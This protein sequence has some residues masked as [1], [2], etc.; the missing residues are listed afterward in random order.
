ML[1]TLAAPVLAENTCPELSCP[2]SAARRR[3]G[4]QDIVVPWPTLRNPFIQSAVEETRRLASGLNLVRTEADLK[5]FRN[6]A[7]I[8]DYVFPTAQP[9]PLAACVKTAC[10]LFFLDDSYDELSF[11]GDLEGLRQTME[12]NCAVLTTGDVPAT[13][14]A[15]PLVRYS[16]ALHHDLRNTAIGGE[17]WLRRLGR[18][19]RDYLFKGSLPAAHNYT[20]RQAPE[21]RTYLE[22]RHFDSGMDVALDLIEIAA[23]IFLPDEVVAHQTVQALRQ[24]CAGC[25]AYTNDLYSYQREVIKNNN[26]NNLVHCLM[27]GRALSRREAVHETVWLI[28]ACVEEFQRLVQRLPRWSPDLDPAITLYVEGMW[29][30]MRGNLDFSRSA[31]ERYDGSILCA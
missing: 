10:W 24:L 5:R 3:L 1:L 19:V 20:R 23:E 17:A 14:V 15:S 7:T 29:H 8:A 18:S 9:R 16:R 21:I 12:T 4:L 26:P 28:N 11:D 2:R 30:W 27:T 31:T 22:M 13:A 25:V 6:F